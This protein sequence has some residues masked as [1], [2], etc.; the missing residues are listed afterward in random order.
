MVLRI[1]Q[2]GLTYTEVSQIPEFL[3]APSTYGSPA[4]CLCKKRLDFRCERS[5]TVVDLRRL[6]RF[7]ILPRRL[8]RRDGASVVRRQPRTEENLNVEIREKASSKATPCVSF[9]RHVNAKDC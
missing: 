7:E 1:S 2:A 6:K 3:S 4:Q 9:C 8:D 5:S